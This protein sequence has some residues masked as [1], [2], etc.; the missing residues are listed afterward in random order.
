M[1]INCMSGQTYCAT[2]LLSKKNIQLIDSHED[3]PGCITTL[4]SSLTLTVNNFQYILLVNYLI[5]Q[6][7][8]Q[9]R[10]Y[11]LMLLKHIADWAIS[12]FLRFPMPKCLSSGP[13]QD[14]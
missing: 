9:I 12:D 3:A 6:L 5:E 4:Q 10:V 11:A 1:K 7:L 2:V 13:A 8:L 14:S